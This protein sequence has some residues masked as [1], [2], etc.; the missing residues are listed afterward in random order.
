MLNE[1]MN[2]CKNE[3][4]IES[5]NESIISTLGCKKDNN[6]PENWNFNKVISIIKSILIKKNKNI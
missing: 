3:F 4:M 2:E 5:M 1:S 6:H